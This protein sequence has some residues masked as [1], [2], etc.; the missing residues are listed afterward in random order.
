MAAN[1]I[2]IGAGVYGA[3]VAASLARRGARVVV[4]EAGLPAHGTSGAT[5]SWT[6]ASA[7]PAGPYR[8]LNVAGLAAHRRLAAEATGATRA[9]WYH[10][11]GNL[12][13]AAAGDDEARQKLR[14]KVTGLLDD[15]YQA[16]WLSRSEAADIEPGI[17]S[18]GLPAD[19]IAFFPHEGWVAPERLISYLLSV[20]AAHGAELL[21]GD[22]VVAL[23]TSAGQVSAVRMASGRTLAVAAVVNCAGPRAGVIAELVG[24]DLPMRNTCGLLVR[25]SAAALPVSRVVHA[26]RVH[27]RPDGAAG[28]LMHS[29]A[30]DEA[31]RTSDT[32]PVVA[33][34]TAVR[35]LLEAGRALCPA[36]HD[37]A[38]DGVRIGERPIPGDGLPVLGRAA[39]LPNFHFAV[40]HS[41]VTLCLQAGGLVA[42]EVL[43]L[44]RDEAL[45]PFRFERFRA[46][47]GPAAGAIPS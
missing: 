45:A 2:V 36:A 27:L 38:V 14:A 31:V 43:G 39:D 41:G 1:V 13:W 47:P 19:E 23:E 3:A 7:K 8:D 32:G 9:D 17:D 24:L 16:R 34:D 15:G 26:P 30:L 5:F 18:A 42:D 21:T 12:Q 44:D 29:P 4:V 6:N 10:E 35:R 11:S 37:A 40:S 46:A 22:G 20:A 33:D 28:L 25:V